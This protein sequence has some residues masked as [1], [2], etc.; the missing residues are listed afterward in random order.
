MLTRREIQIK[1]L[2]K[3]NELCEKADVKYVLH[4]H[5]AFL[6]Y[7]GEPIEN[8]AS[9]EVMMCQGDAEKVADLLD[10]DD[11]YFEDFRTNPKF[12]KHFMMLGYKDSLD[13]KGK[14]VDFRKSRHIENNCIHIN[15]RFIEH[16]TRKGT[17]KKL[18]FKRRLW[19]L[20]YLD[21]ETNHLWYLNYS[22]KVLN[23]FY[24]ITGNKRS[25]NRR[26]NVKKENFSIW[27]WDE[28]KNYPLVKMAGTKAIDSNL[29][30][31]IIK[32][33]I[34]GIP[35][36]IFEDFNR[37]AEF[38]YGKEWRDKKWK[39]PTGFTSSIINWE[40]FS[41]DPEI[42]ESLDKMQ[43]LYE[44]IYSRSPIA[45]RHKTVIRDMKRHVKQ[46]GRVIHTREEFIGQKE[47]ILKLYDNKN[48]EKLTLILKPLMEAQEH[49]IRVGYTF[50]VDEDIDEILD[51]YLR[52]TD[53][54]ELAD[55]IKKQRIDI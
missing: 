48:I 51:W 39:G 4:G 18:K 46:S 27:T 26:Y 7:F 12:D 54:K 9:L 47:D 32:K 23:G 31:K 20:R 49:G 38:Y 33:D 19:K 13:L 50:S 5:G 45:K 16:P 36:Y 40:E 1:L 10:D 44:E 25:I 6:A 14:E 3:L 22:K 21:L 15:I 17:G 8:L 28:I 52:E 41:N 30:D 55:K 42:Q 37:Y 43:M 24:H 34:E 2:R 35:A 29:F 11:F 53:R